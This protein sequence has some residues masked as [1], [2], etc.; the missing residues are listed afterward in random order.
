M[1]AQTASTHF[2]LVHGS[3][4]GSWCWDLLRPELEQRGHRVTAIDLPS[5]GADVSALGD[6][7]ADTQAVTAAAALLDGPA[8][9]VGHSYGGAVISNAEYPAS[10]RRLVF[11]G[12]FMPDAGR[13]FTSYLPPGPLP[14]YVGLNDDGT[15]TVPDGQA[16]PSFYADCSDELVGWAGSMLR[17]QSQ[18]VLGGVNARAAWRAIPS[19]Y[20][21]L[22][23]DQALPPDF[24]AMF[25]A[26]ATETVKFDASHSPFLSKPAQLADLFDTI[27]T[28]SR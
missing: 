14:P 18:A 3:W 1:T 20:V 11:L 27:A 28:G 26:Q 25:A 23:E 15:S 5:V 2:L 19:T 17:P 12:A 10:V 7:N 8:V 22:T 21:L 24:Q 4:H 16:R 6:F 9:V 13:A